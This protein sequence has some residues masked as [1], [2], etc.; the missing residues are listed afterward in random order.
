MRAIGEKTPAKMLQDIISSNDFTIDNT[1]PEIE[2]PLQQ[3][4][5]E[6]EHLQEELH[7]Q[8]IPVENSNETQENLPDRATEPIVETPT[9][10]SRSPRR[11]PRRV[12]CAS[13][14]FVTA[15]CAGYMRG[16]MREKAGLEMRVRAA[17]RT[18]MRTSCVRTCSVL[19]RYNK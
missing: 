12:L 7:Q 19:D 8:T 10:V 14:K 3:A 18:S 15:Y 2:R 1:P 5:E 9:R 17:L 6:P 13:Y 16:R 4:P 11:P